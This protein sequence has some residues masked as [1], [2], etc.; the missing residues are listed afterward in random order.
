MKDY[1]LFLE[2][3]TKITDQNDIAN[4]LNN[5]FTNIGQVVVKC[6]KYKG[7]E[8]YSYK[9]VNYVFNFRMLMKKL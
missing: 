2:T 6:I 7:N 1:H 3:G 5:Y 9:N 8:G 4:K